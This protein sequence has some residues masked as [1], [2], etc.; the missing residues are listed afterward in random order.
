MSSPISHL[1]TGYA[2][3][4]V[5]LA[6][7]PKVAGLPRGTRLLTASVFA[8][9]PDADF[10]AGWIAN[11]L[12]AYHNNVSHSFAF[13]AMV[14]LVATL[15]LHRL[16]PAIRRLP[17]WCF[18]FGCYATHVLVDYAT[19][20]RGVML[21]WPFLNERL[22]SPLILFGGVSWSK[23]LATTDHLWTALNDGIYGIIVIALAELWARIVRRRSAVPAP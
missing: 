23:G 15:V 18:S 21:F 19:R 3:Y 8:M 4:R 20:G 16:A 9:A 22:S 12:P 17:F 5:L 2:L 11:D 1:A 6:H 7:D 10:I 14:C 13:G